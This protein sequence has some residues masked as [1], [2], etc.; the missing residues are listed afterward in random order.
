MD[1]ERGGYFAYPFGNQWDRLGVEFGRTDKLFGSMRPEAVKGLH[2]RLQ[3][4][5]SVDD[6]PNGLAYFPWSEFLAYDNDEVR[7]GR[8]SMLCTALYQN[9]RRQLYFSYGSFDARYPFQPVNVRDDRFIKF[10]IKNYAR[11]VLSSS[12]YQTW[13]VGS[14]NGTFRYGNY[15]LFDDSGSFI[16]GQ[17]WE[18]PFPQNDSEWVSANVYML[19]RISEWSPN[20]K[21][22]TNDVG[23]SDELD[24]RMPEFMQYLGGV[25][26]ET[27]W[28]HDAGTS[29][30]FR[31]DFYK[32]VLDDY[33]RGVGG[34]LELLE[35]VIQP[36]DSTLLRRSYVAFLIFG[37]EN[38]FFGPKDDASRELDPSLWADMRNRLGKQTGGLQHAQESGRGT[39]S[40]LY[41]RECEGG[42]CY[43]NWTGTYKTIQLPAGRTYF[44]RFGSQ[45]TSLSLGDME[46]DYVLFSPSERVSWPSI[47]P[48]LS[49]PVSGPVT[50]RLDIDPMFSTGATIRYTTDGSDPTSSSPIYNGSLT[51]WSSATVK[52]RAFKS[53]QLDSFVNIARYDVTGTPT[54]EFHLTSDSGSEFLRNDF[55]LVRLSSVSGSTVTVNYSV[56]GGSATAGVDYTSVSGTLVFPPGE[57]Y[58]FFRLP[59][60]NDSSTE[61][62]ETI[63]VTL[64]SPSN[65]FLGGKSTYTYTILDNDGGGGTSPNPDPNPN[66]NPNPDPTP[67]D[68]ID[69]TKVSGLYSGLLSPL[70]VNF[71]Q[72]GSLSLTLNT[73]RTFTARVVLNGVASNMSG[74]FSTSGAFT[75]TVPGT[76]SSLSLQIDPLNST[77]RINGTLSQSGSRVANLVAHRRPLWSSTNPCPR[78]GNYTVTLPADTNQPQS[79]YPQGTGFALITVSTT[80][81]VWVTGL[82]GDQT[83]ISAGSNASVDG[84]VPFYGAAYSDRGAVTGWFTL[85]DTSASNHVAGT[86]DWFKP[87]TTTGVYRNSFIGRTTLV[88]SRYIAPPT[89]PQILSS[90]GYGAFSYRGG[91]L[92]PST[93]TVYVTIS[94]TNV[95][96]SNDGQPLSFT[97]DAANGFFSGYLYDSARRSYYF[98]GAVLQRQNT[99][100]GLF[101]GSG[102][103]G[104]VTFQ[105]QL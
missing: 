88:G 98:R 33:N 54:V 90:P 4:F 38:F 86:F 102:V 15:G 92:S 43:L 7:Q 63:T 37:A 46:G 24:W 55:P 51:L 3:H 12:Y 73:G 61:F 66:P 89:R 2:G 29:D 82:L 48:R 34:A 81:S 84:E 1:T 105:P 59:I 60:T 53:G 44:N 40:R 5:A 16:F 80:G 39:G 71:A 17:R 25:I 45:I 49:G 9:R 31:N 67:T 91:G 32:T 70:A 50:V 76:S 75:G 103:T 74:S 27:F 20:I 28:Y 22:A 72:S 26:R 19:R 52:A 93:N 99:G 85:R 21:V 47:N 77:G 100:A 11:N 8:P 65:A 83:A 14:D 6:V 68:P 42:I 13:W 69:F 23:L 58:R 104:S 94:S 78:A 64:S 96:R 56:S 87:A 30:W 101:T 36:W 79:S 57:Q 97:Y 35:M 18:T 62:N 95:V 10:W 41:W